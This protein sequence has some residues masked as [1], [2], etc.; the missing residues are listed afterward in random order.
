MTYDELAALI[1]MINYS[2]DPSRC[3]GIN[4]GAEHFDS[5]WDPAK[6]KWQKSRGRED[7]AVATRRTME[8]QGY[9]LRR[10]RDVAPDEEIV[11][12][13]RHRGE[14]LP[15]RPGSRPGPARR[16]SADD[17]G[18]GGSEA[19]ALVRYRQRRQQDDASDSEASVPSRS[20]VRA[21]STLGSST[22]EAKQIR[23]M[24]RKK[25]VTAAL[26][27]VAT[28]HAAQKVYS[29]IENHDKRIREVERGELSPQEAKKKQRSA[30]W[31]DAAALGIAA[32]GIHGAISEW[33]ETGFYKGRDGRWYFDGAGP[34]S[35]SSGGDSQRGGS[36]QH[37]SSSTRRLKAIDR[38]RSR[39]RRRSP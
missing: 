32:L 31:Q 25:W 17:L 6:G 3:R 15:R 9:V 19:G 4:W 36:S 37:G 2:I 10:R 21:K 30:H 24:K 33:R 14:L 13:V 1:K 38:A 23:K 18:G 34:Q 35:L 28:I 39:A 7:R 16:S 20:R 11:E 27:S 12:T 5:V 8:E 26:A 29:S 22:D